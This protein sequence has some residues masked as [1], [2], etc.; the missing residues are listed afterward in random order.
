[1]LTSESVHHDPESSLWTTNAVRRG[2]FLRFSLGLGLCS[3]PAESTPSSTT[4]GVEVGLVLLIRRSYKT[5]I[6]RAFQGP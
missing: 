1:M 3:K 5:L 4:C 6:L 2:L